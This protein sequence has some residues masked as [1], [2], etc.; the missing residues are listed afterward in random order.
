[1]A[2]SDFGFSLSENS[3]NEINGLIEQYSQEIIAIMNGF[4]DDLIEHISTANYD[5][6]LKAV[7]GI[8]ELYNQSVRYELKKSIHEQ[9][10]E[11]CES[12]TSFAERME[13][14]DE[15]EQVASEIEEVLSSIFDAGI[16]NRLH[17]VDID[18]RTSASIADFE[19]VNEIFES[20]ASKVRE[21]SED[22]NS[23]A[24]RLGEENEFYKFIVPVVLAYSGGVCSFF[25]DA[26]KNLETLEDSYVTKMA[27]KREAVQDNK[28]E[29]DLSDLLDFSD[30]AYAGMGSVSLAVAE[31]KKDKTSESESNVSAENED[32]SEKKYEKLIQA[33]RQFDGKACTYPELR[34]KYD[35]HLAQ[36]HKNLEI[37]VKAE[38]D[39]RDKAL[40]Q[41]HKQLEQQLQSRHKELDGRYIKGTITLQQAEYMYAESCDKAKQLYSFKER[42]LWSEYQN[43]CQQANQ[44]YSREVTRCDQIA[45][46]A[47]QNRQL[48]CKALYKNRNKYIQL[49]LANDITE[50]FKEL[51][52]NINDIC[53]N[54]SNLCKQCAEIV[55]YVNSKTNISHEET[56]NSTN[57]KNCS[58]LLV[59][60]DGSNLFPYFSDD[61]KEL[62]HL[63][64]SIYDAGSDEEKINNIWG[65]KGND[66]SQNKIN[67][68]VQCMRDSVGKLN[69]E[70]AV[71]DYI[72]KQYDCINETGKV[73]DSSL[74]ELILVTMPDNIPE[75]RRILL[76]NKY[77]DEIKKFVGVDC[78]KYTNYDEKYRKILQQRKNDADPVT[79]MLFDKI[80][81]KL[82]II[83]DNWNKTPHY[84][85]KCNGIYLDA[86]V[87]TNNKR[88]DGST[89]YHELGHMIDY[90]LAK[91]S[92]GQIRTISADPIFSKALED[93]RNRII[94]ILTDNPEGKKQF[95]EQLQKN[96]MYHSISDIIGGMK[97]HHEFNDN[98]QWGR[99]GH[100]TKEI[101][102]K[103][104][105]DESYWDREK[106]LEKETFAHLYEAFMGNS[107]KR[108][109]IR[110]VMPK[111]CDA[112]INVLK[113]YGGAY[114]I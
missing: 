9:W 106:Q 114:G 53:N 61:Y 25:R 34:K 65:Q 17:E 52:E 3:V 51:T 90:T 57:T 86:S 63:I 101:D 104:V 84:D 102:G 20:A 81:G 83:S 16:D 46:K 78:D 7:D 18:G 36:Y 98:R 100:Y 62:T 31:K 108:Q 77:C 68:F 110:N 87:D 23:E 45:S 55:D 58:E 39:K 50:C 70:N 97:I 43:I 112:F 54:C 48:A 37:K 64:L 26:T 38:Y 15:S 11:A 47:F 22:F 8:I 82:R 107:E 59:E 66:F 44:M 40:Q 24:E 35:E 92:G 42:T 113:K 5:K 29:V 109:I 32:S 71:I 96:D 91:E 67:S 19:N 75:E 2:Q 28:Q 69:D 14:G 79:R 105:Y 12:M 13:M 6:L 4:Q 21:L 95:I 76:G 99:Y 56:Q 73:A 30:L 74:V 93:D 89:F 88:G 72:H 111:T 27:E 103:R 85:P 1:M 41:Y 49:L 60:L 80:S 94:K 33:L 10:Q